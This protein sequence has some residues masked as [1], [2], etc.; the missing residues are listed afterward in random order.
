MYKRVLGI[1]LTIALIISVAACSN[2]APTTEDPKD[3]TSKEPIKVRVGLPEIVNAKFAPGED[4]NNNLWTKLF[5]EKFNIDVVADWVT[6]EYD[7]KINLA[8]ASGE[9]PD[10]FT[11]NIVQ[12]NQLMEAGMLEDL[13]SSYEEYASQSLRDM[14]KPNQD[15]VETAMFDGKLM[16][17]PRL[18]Y[19][20]ETSTSFLWVRKDWLE[21]TGIKEVK[22]IEDYEKLMEAFKTKNGAKFGTM[23]DKTLGAFF[24]MASSF[25]AYPKI[26][27]DGPD[28]KIVYG[29]TLPETKNAL[30]K[31]AEWYKKGYIKKD[32]ATMDSAAML[33]DAYNGEVGTYAQQNWAGWQVGS[34][35]VKNKGDDTYFVSLNLPSIDGEK[36]YYPRQFSN[37]VYNVVRKG[38]KHPEVLVELINTYVDVLDDAIGNGTMTL[39]EVLPFNTNEMHHIT[40]PFKVEFAHYQDIKDVSSSVITGEEHLGSGNAVLFYNEILKWKNNHDLVGLGRYLQMGYETSSLALGIAH[41]DNEQIKKTKVWGAMPEVMLDY[42]TTL[43]DLLTEGYTKI[44]MGLEDISYFDT[45]IE[46][47]RHAG[48]DEVTEAVNKM[49]GK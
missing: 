9:L 1:I 41:V 26:W 8:I 3:T 17:I 19:G 15:I 44:I 30:A 24:E 33:R 40:G 48:G 31:W 22:T 39:E 13:T 38:Y 18:H 7:T 12:L 43:D 36:I 4:Y 10:M 49:Y 2:S 37:S 11:V 34:D 23:L 45:L 29:A 46:A 20:D 5:K 42:G 47:W 28:G 6:T 32:F 14:I 25:H 16:A 27:V 35:M 21:G